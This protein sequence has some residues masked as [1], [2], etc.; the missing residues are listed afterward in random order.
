MANDKREGLPPG[1]KDSIKKIIRDLHG[2]TSLEKAKEEFRR[3]VGDAS[4]E[5][6][7][8]AEQELVEQGLPRDELR[9]LCDV[10]LAVMGDALHGQEAEVPP[11]HP[12]HTFKEEHKRI[13]DF[14][15]KLEKTVA[16][17][18]ESPSKETIQQRLPLLKSVSEH[19]MEIEKHNE[20]E[21]NVLFP[22]LERRGITEPPA[23]MWAEHNDLREM[24]KR[25]H[26]LVDG[27][28]GMDPHDFAKQASEVTANL[29]RTLSSHIFKE[30]NILYPMALQ[31]IPENEW[32]D[33]RRQCDE[34]GYCCFTPESARACGDRA[35]ARLGQSRPRRG[36][37]PLLSRPARSRTNNLS[38]CSIPCR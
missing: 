15:D 34:L 3:T 24:K 11:G 27:A 32:P 16:E 12:V 1:A 23:V 9:R 4:A 31:T 20:R 18:K 38:G 19:L 21:E 37:V 5:D 8:R 26:G 7:G 22:S 29:V 13:L 17:I 14:L 33:I 25:L 10:H 30:N 36:K 28:A 2:G 35:P 6:I